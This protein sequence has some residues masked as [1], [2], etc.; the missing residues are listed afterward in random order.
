[1]ESGSERLRRVILGRIEHPETADLIRRALEAGIVLDTWLDGQPEEEV[2]PGAGELLSRTAETLTREALESRVIYPNYLMPPGYVHTVFSET[3]TASALYAAQQRTSYRR[4]TAELAQEA[5]RAVLD[6]VTR[7]PEG[8][9]AVGILYG[10]IALHEN[11]NAIDYY[12]DMKREDF[13]HGTLHRPWTNALLDDELDL[14][15]QAGLVEVYR[16]R[17]ADILLLT[18]SGR[19]A[20]ELSRRLMEASGEL[21][22]RS[23]RQRWVRFHEIEYDRV[24]PIV[25]PDAG[26]ENRRYLQNLPFPPAGHILEIGAGTGRATV[27]LGLARRLVPPGRLVATDPSAK[28]LEQLRRKA[29]AAGLTHIEIVQTAAEELP[30]ADHTFDAVVAVSALHFTDLERAVREMARVTKPGGLVTGWVPMKKDLL[31]IPIIPVWFRPVIRLAER[32]GVSFGEYLGVSPGELEA[33]FRQG[34]LVDVRSVP[35]GSRVMTRDYRAFLDFMVMGGSFFQ[36]ILSRVPYEERKKLL[37]YLDQTG[38]ELVSSRHPSDLAG[39]WLAEEIYGRVPAG[40][41]SL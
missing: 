16:R 21:K 24:G 41:A 25:F 40:N 27:D 8:L 12:C 30:F 11:L 13:V 29:Q 31:E 32:Y 36:N 9:L 3:L 39:F 5:I 22:W 34:G 2:L 28:L 38:S 26:T 1:M 4:V 10:Q 7:E 33:V 35:S 15:I 37:A 6:F 20:M 18:D 19:E 14:Y 17:D 23:R